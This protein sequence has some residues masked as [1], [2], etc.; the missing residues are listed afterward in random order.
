MMG[1]HTGSSTCVELARQQPGLVRRIVMNS[2]AIFSDEELVKIKA[3]YAAQPIFEDGSHLVKRWQF[4]IPFYGPKVPRDILARNFA[5]GLRGGPMS[6][7]GHRAAFNYPLAERLTEIAQPIL[8]INPDDDLVEETPRALPLAADIRMH[9]LDGL[10]H[11][12]FDIV[13]GEMGRIFRA[14]LDAD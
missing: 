9:K 11:A 13:P 3:A 5:E 7:W 2:A 4:M 1:Y 14:F 12:W 10:G 8:L 6:W